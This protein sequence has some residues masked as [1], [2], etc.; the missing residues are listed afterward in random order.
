MANS[1]KAEKVRDLLVEQILAGILPPGTRLDETELAKRLKVSRTPVREALRYLGAIGLANYE[2]HKGSRVA[3]PDFAGLAD[4]FDALVELEC[5]CVRVAA[6]RMEG[7]E[8]A[9]LRTCTEATAAARLIR[10]GVHNERL[11]CVTEDT[12]RRLVL[13]WRMLAPAE[14]TAQP[15]GYPYCSEVTD[16]V[17]NGQA[18][19]AATAVRRQLLSQRP[20]GT[21]L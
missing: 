7:D 15:D 2:P 13:V 19:L 16:A 5:L 21:P 20:R 1:S 18:D 17:M 9:R 8:R 4:L 10:A 3:A 6:E 14:C 12:L 11:T